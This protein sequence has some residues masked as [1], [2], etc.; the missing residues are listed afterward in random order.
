VFLRYAEQTPI[1]SHPGDSNAEL[2][3]TLHNGITFV[4]ACNTAIFDIEYD[5]V[6]GTITRFVTQMSNSTLANAVL[7]VL[8]TT[9]PEPYLQQYTG[10]A[11]FSSSTVQAMADQMALA[12]S[13]AGLSFFAQ[14]VVPAPALAAQAWSTLLVTRMPLAPLYALIITNLLFVVTGLVLVLLAIALTVPKA[15]VRDIQG[16]LSIAGLL[17]DRFESRHGKQA[18]R[19]IEGLFE[20]NDGQS[21][22]RVGI[23][24]STEGGYSFKVIDGPPA[25]GGE[26]EV[27]RLL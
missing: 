13:K 18:V 8:L 10:L 20:E 14:A 17:A 19:K 25:R 21:S 5:S 4:L 9:F 12:Y 1:L 15:E 2:V 27:D 24:R 7:S 22:V 26:L 23:D 3:V 11:A 6:N 16:R